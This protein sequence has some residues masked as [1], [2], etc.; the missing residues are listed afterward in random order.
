MKFYLLLGDFVRLETILF[1]LIGVELGWEVGATKRVLT[2]V[3]ALEILI[4]GCARLA[5]LWGWTGTGLIG[6]LFIYILTFFIINQYK[7]YRLL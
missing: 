2:G 7:I 6:L 3:E 5:A 4:S 1:I